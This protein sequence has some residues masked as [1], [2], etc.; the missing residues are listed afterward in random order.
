MQM[1]PFWRIFSGILI[2]IAGGS[3]FLWLPSLLAWLAPNAANLQNLDSLVSLLSVLIGLLISVFGVRAQREPQRERKINTS[4]GAYFEGNIDS[5]GGAVIGRDQEIKGQIAVG[6]INGPVTITTAPEPGKAAAVIP[7]DH[8]DAVRKIYIQFILDKYQFLSF[9]G[10][11]PTDSIEMRIPLADLYVPLKARLE[12]PK[13]GETW[14]AEARLGGRKLT[15]AQM[16][17]MKLSQPQA[18]LDLLKDNPGLI[19][20]GDPGAG[21]STFLKYMALKAA[22]G[23]TTASGL[24][25]R[26]PV[27]VP[28]SA[29]ATVLKVKEQRIDDFIEEYFCESCK[30]LPVGQVLRAELAAGSALVMLDGLDEVK[31]LDLRHTVIDRVVNFYTAHRRN[32]N[33][34]VLTSRVVG[35]SEVRPAAEGLLEA[36]LV[37]FDDEE[38]ADFA[39][40]WTLVIEHQTQG[41]GSAAR[42]DAEKER[43]ELLAAVSGSAGV[44]RLAANPLLLTILAVMKRQGVSLPERRVE[45]YEQYVKTLLS[46]WNRARSLS[47]RAVGRDLDVIDTVQLL[48]PLALWMH[49]HSPGLGLVKREDLLRKLSEAYVQRG[50]K[51]SQAKARNFLDDVHEHTSLLLERGPG[52]YGFIHLTFEEYLAG[53]GIA[54]EAGG[55]VEDIYQAI[56]QNVGQADWREVNQLALGY[57]G[58]IQQLPRAAGQVLEKLIERQPGPPGSA[59]LL[60]GWAAADSGPVG[61]PA[62]VA[63]SVIAALV[64]TMQNPQVAKRERR[65]AGLVLGRLGWLPPDLDEFVTIP[66]GKFI[67]GEGKEQREIPYE[68]QIAKYPVT[69]SQYARFIQHQGY[70]TRSYWSQAGWKWR[71]EKKAVQPRYWLDETFNN[72]VFPVV[73]V[74]IYE[75]EAYAGWLTE[76]LRGEGTLPGKLKAR[77]P[78]EVE[79]ERAARGTDGREFPWGDKFDPRASNTSEDKGLFTTCAATYPMGRSMSGVW[80][81]SGNVFE[82]TGSKEGNYRIGRGGSWT[83][84]RGSARCASRYRLDPDSYSDLGFRPVLSLADSGS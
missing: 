22:A 36:T 81:M 44:R 68:Y 21:K 20:L 75:A 72:S 56:A 25:G 2:L 65:D 60:A 54:L 9:R 69:N 32:G 52:E 57:I 8:L 84:F 10:L 34:F 49:A 1:K 74:T 42:F 61:I 19:L 47:G 66:A 23:E 28:L 43:Q 41:S 39:A 67:Y 80:D 16:K 83:F 26:L 82:W 3:A 13:G 31:D 4:G 79:W 37:D 64:A 24:G 55:Q 12:L 15:D 35:Y 48:A 53:V 70:Q 58:L 33:K 78:N 27:L 29:Y 62:S 6:Q 73:G 30:N 5:G 11:G 76:K 14:S 63:Q 46:T 71:E 50:E 7:G 45:L 77:L 17:E 51:D 59:V 18:V 40:R 38:I